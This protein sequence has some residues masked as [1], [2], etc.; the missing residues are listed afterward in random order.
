MYSKFINYKQLDNNN[1]LSW[2][3]YSAYKFEERVW[4]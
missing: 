4:Y 2:P 1:L 3:E